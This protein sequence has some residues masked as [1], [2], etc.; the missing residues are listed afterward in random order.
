M[1]EDTITGE[2]VAI[3]KEE[4]NLV[5]IFLLTKGVSPK[6]VR[7]YFDKL[8]AP[9]ALKELLH[10]NYYILRDLWKKRILNQSQWNLLFPV[11]G[12]FFHPNTRFLHRP[13]CIK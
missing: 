1:D 11:N 6:A 8:F 7:A 9:S 5:R 3:T 4:E 12:K 13:G 10:K 2:E